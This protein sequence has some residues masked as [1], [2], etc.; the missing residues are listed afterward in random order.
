MHVLMTA[1]AVGGVWTYSIDLCRALRRLGWTSTL[2]CMG[3][4]PSPA[5]R[6]EARRARI[7]LH[8]LEGRLEWMSEPWDDLSHAGAWLQDIAA[9]CGCDLVHLNQ[10]AHASLPWR[11]PVLLVAHS[12][13]P[14]WWQAVHGQPAPAE[15]WQRYEQMVIRA[16]ESAARVVAPTQ[17]MLDSLRAHYGPL[18]QSKATV[19]HHGRCPSAFQPATKQKLILAAG[20]LWDQAKNMAL[21]DEVAPKLP[22]PVH[23]AGSTLGPCG[24]EWKPQH[25]RS[26]GALTS[27]EL[28]SCLARASIF[29]LPA[30]YEPFGLTALEAALCGCAL[31]LGDIPSLREVWGDAAVYVPPQQPQALEEA[32]TS[33]CRSPAALAQLAERGMARASELTAERMAEAY[34]ELYQ[35][36]APARVPRLPSRR[37]SAPPATLEADRSAS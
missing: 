35:S 22:W 17:A 21:L 16:L 31:V 13:V 26:L 37:G 2:A 28:A 1:D 7:T 4:P 23:L 10:Y 3:P 29:V 30:R 25:A 5:Q 12:C 9:Q 24:E 27:R 6:A 11:L 34:V 36:L 32:I 15:P 19:I 33:L 18:P 20:R 8:D 14:S